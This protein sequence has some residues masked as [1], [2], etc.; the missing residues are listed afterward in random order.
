MVGVLNCFKMFWNQKT[1]KQDNN[2]NSK[3]WNQDPKRR[4]NVYLKSKNKQSTFVSP[5]DLGP[6]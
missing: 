6:I 2:V 5:L 1:T 4:N 3:G